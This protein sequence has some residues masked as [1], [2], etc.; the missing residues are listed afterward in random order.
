MDVVTGV[1]VVRGPDWKWTWRKP[2]D[3]GEGHVGT[4]ADIQ[5]PTDGNAIATVVIQWDNGNRC[6]YRYGT[7]GSYDLRVFDNAPAGWLES[8]Q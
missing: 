3:G 5:Q 4:V 7:E 8:M 1:R 2:E 6:S